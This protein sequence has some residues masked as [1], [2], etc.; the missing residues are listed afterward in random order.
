M[1]SDH[2]GKPRM[3]IFRQ[4]YSPNQQKF[5]APLDPWIRVI[6]SCQV[7][8]RGGISPSVSW[9]VMESL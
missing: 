5:G 1:E 7:S 2:P 8:E 3:P 4:L 9:K 6:N